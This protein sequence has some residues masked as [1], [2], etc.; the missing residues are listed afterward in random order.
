MGSR[1]SSAISCARSTF[2]QVIGNQAPALTVGSLATITA[3]RSDTLPTPTTTPA[4]GAP[5]YSSYMSCAAHNPTS[6]SE[7]PGS[8]R[9]ATRSRALSFPFAASRAWAVAPPPSS[10]ASS[11]SC[12]NAA[13][14]CQCSRRFS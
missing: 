3:S 14:R 6:R 8:Q 10:R 9:A 4:A 11:F 5:P 2:L 12:N 1:F 13:R 7:V